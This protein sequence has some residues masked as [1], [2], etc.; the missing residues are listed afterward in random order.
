MQV[1]NA[2]R[3]HIAITFKDEVTEESRYFTTD[4]ALSLH[5]AELDFILKEL[6]KPYDGKTIIVT[7]HGPHPVCQHT[8]FPLG[9]ISSGFHSDLSH[10]IDRY[11]IDAWIYGH[12][13]CNLD[14]RVGDTRIISN[15][16]GYPNEDVQDFRPDLLIEV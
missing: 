13:H 16:A 2:L 7:H 1:G 10:I 15:Q 9:P 6:K 14:T 12:T 8:S 5:V 4:D 11:S 3:D